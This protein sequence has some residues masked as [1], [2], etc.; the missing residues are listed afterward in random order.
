MMHYQVEHIAGMRG[1]GAR[2]IPPKCET[3]R[4]HGLCPSRTRLAGAIIALSVCV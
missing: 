3:M 2:Y 4:T 1:S